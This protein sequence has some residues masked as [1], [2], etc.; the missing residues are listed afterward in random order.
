MHPPNQKSLAHRPLPLWSNLNSA[1]LAWPEVNRFVT[2]N[3][4]VPLVELSAPG[5]RDPARSESHLPTGN[6]RHYVTN[7]AGPRKQQDLSLAKDARRQF[8]CI[9]SVSQTQLGLRVGVP[10]FRTSKNRLTCIRHCL[11]RV[12]GSVPH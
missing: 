5:R 10:Y 3:P 7:A 11:P 4:M 6:A 1:N 2:E 12:Q 9:L 8:L